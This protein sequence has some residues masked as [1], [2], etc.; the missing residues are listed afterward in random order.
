[1]AADMQ[2]DGSYVQ[3]FTETFNFVHKRNHSKL[4]F[5]LVFLFINYCS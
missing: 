3:V 5:L 1:M 4:F 2:K